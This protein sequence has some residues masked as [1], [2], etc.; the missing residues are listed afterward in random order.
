MSGAG[1]K[2]RAKGISLGGRWL[3]NVVYFS[4]YFKLLFFNL[5]IVLLPPSSSPLLFSFQPVFDI[6]GHSLNCWSGAPDSGQIRDQVNAFHPLNFAAAASEFFPS[7]GPSAAQ[8]M[9][10]AVLLQGCTGDS[11]TPHALPPSERISNL[12]QLTF[13]KVWTYQDGNG[14]VALQV[15][16]HSISPA[17]WMR[18]NLQWFSWCS[19]S[20]LQ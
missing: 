20:K 11:Y 14:A 4:H 10:G 9:A 1:F 3:Q 2:F 16:H 5:I 12:E 6:Y 13:G 19:I 8:P 15:L 17:G 18:R 7:R